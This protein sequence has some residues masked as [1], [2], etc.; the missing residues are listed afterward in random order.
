MNAQHKRRHPAPIQLFMHPSHQK[1]AFNSRQLLQPLCQLQI[2]PNDLLLEHLTCSI[3]SSFDRSLGISIFFGERVSTLVQGSCISCITTLFNLFLTKTNQLAT[4]N[5]KY[6]IYNKY[7]PHTGWEGKSLQKLL[8]FLSRCLETNIFSTLGIFP[9]ISFQIFSYFSKTYLWSQAAVSCALCSMMH[10]LR[11]FKINPITK[12]EI[13][14]VTQQW[15]IC[16]SIEELTAL[17][18]SLLY[19]TRSECSSSYCN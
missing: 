9:Q 15:C 2:A 18:L 14:S 6:L 8:L 11:S 7:F 1:K 19:H 16:T 10:T 4:L 12:F 13:S 3:F 5:L 17:H